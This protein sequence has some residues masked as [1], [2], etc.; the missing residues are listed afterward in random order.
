MNSRSQTIRQILLGPETSITF[1]LVIHR[2]RNRNTKTVR[3][4]NSERNS[5]GNSNSNMKNNEK[6]IRTVFPK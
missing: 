2:N 3:N 5:N 6:D 1:V 4:S